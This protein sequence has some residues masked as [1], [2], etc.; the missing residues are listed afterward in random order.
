MRKLGKVIKRNC[1]FKSTHFPENVKTYTL[2]TIYKT[3]YIYRNNKQSLS[4]SLK[5]GLENIAVRD[6][7]N[8]MTLK[9]FLKCTVSILGLRSL[10]HTFLSLSWHKQN[11]VRETKLQQ[12][13]LLGSLTPPHHHC[14]PLQVCTA[15]ARLLQY[16]WTA[17]G[18][19][20]S[21]RKRAAGFILQLLE[22][23]GSEWCCGR[24]DPSHT[25]LMSCIGCVLLLS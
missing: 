20:F 11:I 17:C 25:G 24:Q 3:L 6:C 23:H 16:L 12:F 22:C 15:L 21:S 19:S 9:L 7:S 13:E 5:N 10:S 1:Y 18:G 14:P 2:H 8:T 4:K